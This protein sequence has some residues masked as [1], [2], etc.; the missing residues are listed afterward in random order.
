MKVH[1]E[2]RKP[3]SRECEILAQLTQEERAGTILQSDMTLEQRVK[4]IEQLAAHDKV[5]FFLAFDDAGNII[6]WTT[7]YIGFPPMSFISGFLPVVKTHPDSDAIA[8]SL[9]EEEKRVCVENNHTR[10]EIELVF[11]TDAYRD[12]S[13]RY[14]HWYE[15][16]GF[17][18]AAE[19]I[20]MK[21]NLTEI[22]LPSLDL[23]DGYELKK[24]SELPI[25]EL[26]MAGYRTFENGNDALFVSMSRE[27]QKVT[28]GHFFNPSRPYHDESSPVLMK[29]DEIVGFVITRVEDNEADMGPVGLIPGFRGQG[30][31]SYL[32]V[33]ALR[34]LKSIEV[35][36]VVLDMS[37]TNTRAHNLYTK[38]GF[39]D[40]YR[41]QFY[42]WSP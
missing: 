23:P 21:A 33:H 2:Y 25:E 24:Y 9:I 38:Y 7:D 22:N 13:K 1:V 32:L 28:L 10:L 15:K 8:L 3:D 12:Y 39:V 16:S 37:L 41:K 6:G 11:P 18:F 26:E 14:L 19:E 40:D 5:Q 27:E 36:E 29:D 42:Y 4:S 30:L 20:H 17:Q 31:G 34:S 35:E